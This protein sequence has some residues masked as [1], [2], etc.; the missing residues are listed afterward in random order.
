MCDA[1][2][3]FH[4]N[5]WGN[6]FVRLI[7]LFMSTLV[8]HLAYGMKINFSVAKTKLRHYFMAAN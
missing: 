2:F 1:K 8:I 7:N 6:S 5:C 3:I 4:L